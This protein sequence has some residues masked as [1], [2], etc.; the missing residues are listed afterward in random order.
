MEISTSWHSGYILSMLIELAIYDKIGLFSSYLDLWLCHSIFNNVINLTS[1]YILS[2][3]IKHRKLHIIRFFCGSAFYPRHRIFAVSNGYL[4]PFMI[5]D[6]Q[7]A[8]SYHVSYLAL[9][10]L[11][12]L[13]YFQIWIC[14]FIDNIIKKEWEFSFFD[15]VPTNCSEFK[16][17]AP[18][19]ADVRVGTLKQR[20]VFGYLPVF[21]IFREIR[22]ARAW[23][24]Q[25]TFTQKTFTCSVEL[26]KTDQL[27]RQL[28]LFFIKMNVHELKSILVEFE[29]SNST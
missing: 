18:A 1:F 2:V 28:V 16:N 11:V 5:F 19:P 20:K 3:N 4:S 10:T 26:S 6:T 13:Q 15:F 29:D 17:S 14:D 25:L 22:K 24:E 7:N 23:S 8:C 9:T 27:I 21:E 12:R